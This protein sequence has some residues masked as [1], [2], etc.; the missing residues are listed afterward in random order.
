MTPG[1]LSDLIAFDV[2]LDAL[3]HGSPASTQPDTSG[4][5]KLPGKKNKA[6]RTV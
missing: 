2:L 1:P 5:R 3:L 6:H 4:Q